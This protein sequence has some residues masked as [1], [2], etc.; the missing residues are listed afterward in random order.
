VVVITIGIII[1]IIIII[2]VVVVVILAGCIQLNPH[3]AAL[4]IINANLSVWLCLCLAMALVAEEKASKRLVHI[5][6]KFAENT[7]KRNRRTLMLKL[8]KYFP[9]SN[10]LRWCAFDSCRGERILMSKESS[11]SEVLVWFSSSV[12]VLPRFAMP[13]IQLRAGLF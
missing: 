1:I 3:T 10:Q 8:C 13:L 5:E 11:R 6:S 9:V 4:I 2:I 7:C 12:S